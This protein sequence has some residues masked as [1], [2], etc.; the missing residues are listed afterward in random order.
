MLW[1]RSPVLKYLMMFNF[2]KTF[3]CRE[4]AKYNKRSR[5][6]DYI[7]VACPRRS[8][9]RG[10]GSFGFGYNFLGSF[11]DGF[12]FLSDMRKR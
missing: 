3:C 8:G 11:L 6:Y 1:V 5:E 2:M 4:R 7:I 10:S 12:E 9:S